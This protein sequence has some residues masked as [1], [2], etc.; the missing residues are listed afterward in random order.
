MT[1]KTGDWSASLDVLG[2]FFY[3]LLL[4]A[5]VILLFLVFAKLFS[6]A[7]L[8]GRGRNIRVLE[9]CGVAPQSSVQILQ[10]GGRTFLIG[11]TKDR[12]SIL[13]DITGEAL[14]AGAKPDTLFEHYLKK[15]LPKA[16]T[17]RKED[18]T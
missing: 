4:L 6:S 3:I 14:N 8:S 10:A 11:V 1:P 15:Y 12:I 13:A 16:E 7:R 9:S 5:I 18:G 17:D 2:Q